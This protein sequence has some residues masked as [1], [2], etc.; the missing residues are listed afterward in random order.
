MNS[1]STIGNMIYLNQNSTTFATKIAKNIGQINFQEVVNSDMFEENNKRLK[2][3][4]ETEEN[5][6][7]N[8]NLHDDEVYKVF[9]KSKKHKYKQNQTQQ[10]KS[11]IDLKNHKID[12]TI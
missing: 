6:P 3:T 4:R 12:V 8:E 11:L 5:E 1:V 2:D 10:K 9:G 7:I